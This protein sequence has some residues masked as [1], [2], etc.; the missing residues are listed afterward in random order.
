MWCLTGGSFSGIFAEW[1]NVD[2][3]FQ[4]LKERADSWKAEEGI[5][6]AP[7]F[8][9]I[10]SSSDVK[11][12]VES[13][14]ILEA[15]SLFWPFTWLFK[16]S[17]TKPCS[18]LGLSFPICRVSNLD[19]ICF[20]GPPPA[21]THCGS[22]SGAFWV[23]DELDMEASSSFFFVRKISPE[24]TSVLIFFYFMWDAATAWLDD[25]C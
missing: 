19:E 14:R 20:K 25:W 22:L 23:E 1:V 4:P 7:D 10:F 15:C 6:W 12:H 21:L 18:W 24:L 9:I 17:W 13:K 3:T 8:I 2:Q 5:W 16:C 11:F